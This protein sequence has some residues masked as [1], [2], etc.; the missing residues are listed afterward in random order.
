MRNI[1][2]IF[3]LLASLGQAR[4]FVGVVVD[5]EG[6]VLQDAEVLFTNGLTT[7]HTNGTGVFTVTIG[8]GEQEI[9]IS[10]EGYRELVSYIKPILVRDTFILEPFTVQSEVVEIKASEAEYTAQRMHDVEGVSIN[11]GRKTEVIK[12]ERLNVNLASNNAR[13]IFSSVPG[14]NIWESDNGGLQ[15]GIGARGLDPNRTSNFNTRQDGYDI[16]ADALGYPESYYTPPALALQSIQVIRGAA[17]MQYGPQF[18]GL[19]NFKLKDGK[20]LK[21]HE[22]LLN[23]T[24]GSYGL[25]NGF[26]SMEGKHK[27]LNYFTFYQQK[28]G[29]GFRANAHFDQRT[30]HVHVGYQILPST[31]IGVYATHMNYLAQQPGGLQD[32][33]FERDPTQSKRARNWFRINWNLY[34]FKMKHKFTDRAMLD[35]RV[36]HL[37]A[38]RYALGNLGKINRA[39]R[40]ENRD[41]IKGNYDNYGGELR[42]MQRYTIK[43]QLTNFLV[44]MRYYR[45]STHNEQ[46][47][48]DA[49]AKPHFDFLNPIEPQKTS[50]QFPSQ[51]VSI[52]AENLF[53]I[54]DSWSIVPGVRY[55]YIDTNAKGYYYHR[56]Y[57]GGNILFE[58]KR[59]DERN[60][61]RQILL[62]GLGT[63]YRIH[64][65]EVY[66]NASQN[67]R[68]INFT[69][70]AIVNPNLLVNPDLADESG[71]NLD[72][73]CRG[74]VG[75]HTVFDV[76]AFY[77]GYNNRIGIG[78]QAIRDSE[79][80]VL[81]Y[82][83]YRTNIGDARIVGL[84][85]YTETHRKIGDIRMKAFAN[86]SL[87]KGL[88]SEGASDF[89]GNEVELIPMFNGKVGV[90]IGYAGFDLNYQVAHTSQQYTDATNAVFVADATRGIVP[91]YTVHDATLRWK[92]KSIMIQLAVNNLLNRSYFTRRATA[93]PGPGIIPADPRTFTL[94]AQYILPFGTKN[95]ANRS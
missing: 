61:R 78:T 12:L 42:F 41:L 35:A 88:Y 33:E 89:K 84:E 48:G 85:S 56:V 32:F 86:I 23:L 55:E 75:R 21:G 68:S 36:F 93:Y 22:A 77:L 24:Y 64:S 70:M 19:L 50:Y 6:N 8:D 82:K 43:G 81:D 94:S 15:L 4:D 79:G 39:D 2:Y 25:L 14:L 60:N 73:G 58:E 80:N 28:R 17:S 65:I 49:T 90:G 16:S 72:I 67:Y 87:I 62:L 34:A 13:Q 31:H 45:G 40:I 27:K 57:S 54:T 1:L 7:L 83:A 3:L 9:I 20:A 74:N 63:S 5:Q 46:G 26:A 10:K 18:G 47:F 38:S 53:H 52:F 44:G 37:D 95:A 69:D 51:N 66:A 71:Y 11:A 92:N 59:E 30:A 91:S 76:S 29:D